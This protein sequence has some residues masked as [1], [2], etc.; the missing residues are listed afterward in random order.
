LVALGEVGMGNTTVAAALAAVLLGL[1]PEDVVGLGAGADSTML[2]RK[3]EVVAGAVAR[4]GRTAD[5][6][7]ALATVGGPEVAYLTGV[8]LGAA[9]NG[10]VVVLDGLLTSLAAL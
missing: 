2:A 6:L 5:P 8:V 1:E 3:R 7:Q 4:A 10:S 9:A